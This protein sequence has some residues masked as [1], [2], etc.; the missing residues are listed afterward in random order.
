AITTMLIDHLGAAVFVGTPYYTPM[1][2][3]G[4][5]AFPIFAYCIA[6]GC[7]FT[8]DIGRYALRIGISAIIA[9]PFYVAALHPELMQGL[10]M[11]A[12]LYRV[13]AWLPA[14]MGRPNILFALLAGVL[15]IWSIRDQRYAVTAVLF[16]LAWFFR[17]KLDYGING[18]LLMV[19]FYA[20]IDRPLASLAWVSAVMLVM[21]MPNLAGIATFGAGQ[22]LGAAVSGLRGYV[23]IQLYAMLALPLIYLPMNTGVKVNKYVFYAFY[24]AHLLL[25][26]L[27][28][29]FA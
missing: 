8:R 22:Q 7:V 27:I 19:A 25:I 2:V 23:P 12:D 18:V 9:Q 13:G 15:I 17:G 29:I 5:L 4:R 1:R 3:V 26:A 10:S 6:A 21:G 16:A 20:L 14:A 28:R 24:P 11:P